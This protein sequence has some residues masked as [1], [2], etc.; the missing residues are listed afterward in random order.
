MALDHY[1]SQVHLKNFY[2]KELG[3]LMHAFRKTNMQYFTP[4]SSSIC[5]I[6]EGSTNNYL[7]EERIIEEFL[8]DI[9]PYYDRAVDSVLGKKINQDT[10]YVIAG[11]LSY[12]Y[13]CSPTGIRINKEPLKHI[14]EETADIL[15]KQGK[16]TP[17]D[18]PGHEGKSIKEIFE[19]GALNVEIDPKYPQ[20]IC[21]SDI[22]SYLT[23]FGNCTWEFLINDFQD[24]PFFT[25]DFPIGFER[26]KDPRIINKILPLRPTLAVRVL[27]H[28]EIDTKNPDPSFSMFKYRFRKLSRKEVSDINRL[29][30]RCAEEI[31]LSSVNTE[32]VEPFIRKNSKYHIKPKVTKIPAGGG[33][34]HYF[35]T[36]IVERQQ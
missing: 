28:P 22:I 1:V 14:V 19:S 29:I 33:S 6:D 15:E 8:K 2:S 3:E 12:V 26:S 20:A 4:N 9:E 5:R 30:V 25:S 10:I 13:A 34:Y 11:F 17:I 16:L 21:I 27:P 7:K 23:F 35:S 36:E 18:L 31:V 24:S 32:W